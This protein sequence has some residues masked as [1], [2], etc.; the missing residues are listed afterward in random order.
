MLDAFIIEKIRREREERSTDRRLRIE[1]PRPPEDGW[2]DPR[3]HEERE[4]EEQPSNRGVAI[5]D[6]SL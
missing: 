4:T 1:I 2:R 5:I 6:Y 3:R